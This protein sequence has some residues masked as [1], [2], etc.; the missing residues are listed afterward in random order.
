MGNTGKKVYILGAGATIAHSNNL[1]PDIS[2]IFK[3]AF[4]EKITSIDK[5]R[6]LAGF[7]QEHFGEN[8]NTNCVSIN[9]EDVYTAIEI[10]L[11]FGIEQYIIL[12]SQFIEILINLF[13]KLQEEMKRNN[14]EKS[15]Y[16]K[17]LASQGIRENT[18]ITFNWDIVLDDLLGR[19]LYIEP[20]TKEEQCFD[21]NLGHYK[22]FYYT[23]TGHA[24]GTYEHISVG[25]PKL[26]GTPFASPKD[27]YLLK[28]HGSIDWK[29]CNNKGCRAYGLIFPMREPQEKFICSECL[30]DLNTLIV[31]PT[32]NKPVLQNPFIR[33][34]W[35]FALNAISS[36]D[37]L[38][39]WG[40][41]L[42]PTDFYAQWLL[43]KGA[44]NK[45]LKKIILINPDID[46][47]EFI[48]CFK[49]LFTEVQIL[50]YSTYED[51]AEN[52]QA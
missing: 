6:E 22:N 50:K 24:V 13:S 31:P 26:K 21:D 25:Q 30:E 28:L 38:I 37:S 32:L 7:V 17:F 23:L 5:Y 36:A 27:V 16:K 11:E 34:L 46:K 42:P 1:F 29:V 52:Q 20:E 4:E 43:R 44:K 45:N 49:T 35:N 14:S 10:G 3:K 2:N 41:S 33:R 39:I 8:I 40:Y 15:C 47:E 12:K 18:V 9:A 48:Q 51:F 19:N